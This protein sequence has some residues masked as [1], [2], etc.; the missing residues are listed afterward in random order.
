MK[1]AHITLPGFFV[2]LVLH[3][4]MVFSGQLA[5][6]SI[7]PGFFS[8]LVLHY[9]M[10][11]SGQLAINSD[12]QQLMADSKWC[13]H[14]QTTGLGQCE[15]P[16]ADQMLKGQSRTHDMHACSARHTDVCAL[17]LDSTPVPKNDWHC[18]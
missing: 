18:A 7:L 11:F 3:Y 15:L 2:A 16:N 5:I 4:N 17:P 1:F 14:T 13:T 10:V 9:S 8:G 12:K 6:S